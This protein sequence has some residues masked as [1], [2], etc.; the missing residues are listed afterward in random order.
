VQLHAFNNRK[1]PLHVRNM[2]WRFFVFYVAVQLKL[3]AGALDLR[4]CL[5]NNG[6]RSG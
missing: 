5:R 6:M 2:Q 3:R 1:A 4:N